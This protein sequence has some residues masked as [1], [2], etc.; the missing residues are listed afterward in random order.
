MDALICFVSG[1]LPN[2]T[3][4]HSMLGTVILIQIIIY[5]KLH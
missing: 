1:L 3:L 4:T 2:Y 5:Y